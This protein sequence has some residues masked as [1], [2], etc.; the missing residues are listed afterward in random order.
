MTPARLGRLAWAAG[1]AALVGLACADLMTILE[2]RV[3]SVRITPDTAYLRIGDVALFRAAPLDGS[4]AIVAQARAVWNSSAPA[5][6]A[7]ND[8]GLVVAAAAGVT[9]VTAAANGVEGQSHVQ[10]SGAPAAIAIAAGD[11]QTA[12]VNAA[13]SVPPAVRV[14]DASGNPVPQEPVTFAVTSGGGT[15]SPTTSVLTG[16]DGVALA[17]SWT[18]GPS[19]GTNTLTATASASGLVGNPV[20]FSATATVGPPHAAQ[21]SVIAAPATIAPSSGASSTTITVTVRDSAGSTISGATVV[22]AATGSGNA[23]TQP[24]GPTDLQGQAQGTL[25]STTA[26]TKVVSATVNGTVQVTQTASV[27]VSATAPAGLAIVTQPAGATANVALGTQPVVDVV[28]GFGN[29]VAAA[30][31]VVTVSLA[32]GEGTLIGPNGEVGSVSVAASAGRVVFAGLRIRGPSA[33]SDTLGPGVHQLRFAASGFSDVV[34]ANLNVEV[35]YGYNVQRV[36]DLNGC[37]T[38]HGLTYA[39]SVNQPTG[40]G[41]CAGRLR[42]VPGDTTVASVIY[43]KVRTATPSCGVV[44]PPAG[45]IS[46]RQITIIRD[47]ILQGAKNN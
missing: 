1:T 12:A 30:T 19:P 17:T 42:V 10:V 43:D 36:Y 7:V 4:A 6:A 35:S 24:A 29:R 5:V 45:L 38:C 20:T 39:N 33:T 13:V 15:V 32:G 23:I 22:L 44:M 41:A 27:L 31:D 3:V 18:M 28:D 16:G 37:V 46:A 2:P 26:E 8:T 34:S 21:S 47:W 11:N 9:T 25:S 14:T 40:A